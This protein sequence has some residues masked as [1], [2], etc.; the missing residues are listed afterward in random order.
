MMHPVLRQQPGLDAST[1]WARRG[2]LINYQRTLQ[3]ERDAVAPAEI[4]RE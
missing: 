3:A 1:R 4:T 2:P